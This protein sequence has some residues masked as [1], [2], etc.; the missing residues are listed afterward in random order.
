MQNVLTKPDKTCG[1]HWA[2]GYGLYD[3]MNLCSHY[4]WTNENTVLVVPNPDNQYWELY[5]K[6]N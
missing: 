5:E 2:S 3:L 4:H 6:I 1:E